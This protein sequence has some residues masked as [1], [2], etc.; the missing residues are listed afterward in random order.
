M[1]SSLSSL[2]G[3]CTCRYPLYIYDPNNT[4]KE[5]GKIVKVWAGLGKEII[6]SHKFEVV[7]PDNADVVTKARL[8]GAMFLMNEL[9]FRPEGDS[10][11]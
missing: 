9:F 11:D 10:S 2:L 8:I 7:F 5:V 3:L 1:H 4:E 6:G